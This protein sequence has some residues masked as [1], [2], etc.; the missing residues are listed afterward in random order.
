TLVPV[1]DA[2]PGGY[3]LSRAGEI[4]RWQAALGEG[5]IPALHHEVRVASA[6]LAK[7]ALAR[8]EVLPALADQ[9][10]EA[11]CGAAF[12]DDPGILAELARF[13]IP[14]SAD[15]VADLTGALIRHAGAGD[16][17]AAM[18]SALAPLVAT[19]RED[20]NVTA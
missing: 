7:D 11:V 19:V 15:F 2:P 14:M 18:A 20:F 6:Y 16:D 12:P 1:S 10:V 9:V 8:I 5:C 13:P 4:A 3:E 17:P